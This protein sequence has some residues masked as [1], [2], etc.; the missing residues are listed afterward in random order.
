VV[1]YSFFVVVSGSPVEGVAGFLQK[2][3]LYSDFVLALEQAGVPVDRSKRENFNPDR[4][5]I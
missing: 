5:G 2:S 4:K 3:V 1:A